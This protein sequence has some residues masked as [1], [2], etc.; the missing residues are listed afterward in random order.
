MAYSA[1]THGIRV[2][3]AASYPNDVFVTH[4]FNTLLVEMAATGLISY[5][6]S[7]TDPGALGAN[8]LW[9]K[10]DTGL[11]AA[12]SPAGDAA[13]YRRNDANTSWVAMT[14]TLIAEYWQALNGGGFSINGLAAETT[15]DT[16]NDLLAMYDASEGADNKIS[17]DTLFASRGANLAYAT[18]TLPAVA[19]ALNTFTYPTPTL[20]GSN[21]LTVAVAGT[22]ITPEAGKYFLTTLSSQT[23]NTNAGSEVGMSIRTVRNGAVFNEVMAFEHT[24]LLN[25]NINLIP[26]SAGYIELNGTDYIEMAIYIGTS[27][28]GAFVSAAH[29]GSTFQLFKID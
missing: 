2:T 3:D 13:L 15:L 23:V 18:F 24:Y 27:P 19:V 6:S 11:S 25:N 20:T 29:N 1:Q 12:G 22:Q 9:Y 7:A 8:T 21:N 16:A 26:S 5:T 17:I 28:G 10:P 4:G 14:P